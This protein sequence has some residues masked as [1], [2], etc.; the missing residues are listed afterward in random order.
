MKDTLNARFRAP[1]ADYY[2]RRIII[3]KDEAGEFADTV[4]ELQLDNARILTMRR[5][6]MFEIRKQIEVDYADENLLIYC[7]MGFE[8]MQDNWLLDVFLYSEE[9]RADYWSLVFSELN[10]QNLRPVREYAR[11]IAK[12]FAS[13]ER[14][15]QLRVL[16][17]AYANEQELQT[18]VFCVLAGIKSYGLSQVVRAVLACDPEEENPVLAAIARFCGAAAF[19]QACAD[20]YGYKGA[21]DI[22]RLACHLLATACLNASAAAALPGLPAD[23]SRALPAYG[24][25]VDWLR[26]DREGLMNLCQRVE[27][28]FD[29]VSL[30]SRLGRDALLH[31]SVFPAAD[32]LL[33]EGALTSFAEGR[34]NL[35]DTEALLRARQD[36]PWAADYAPYYAAV[37]AL[38]D[39]QRFCLAYRSGFHYTSL[40]DLWDAYCRELYRM[41]QHYRS[42]CCMYDQAL[43]LGAMALEDAL[44]AAAD[45]AERMY[46]NSYLDEINRTWT[47]LFAQQGLQELA[48]LPQQRH[49]YRDQIAKADSRVY[50]IISDGLRYETAQSLSAQLTG[51]LGGN[52]ECTGMVGTL[53]S[54][55]PVGMAALLPHRRLEM[56]DSL[57]I[58]CDGRGTEA[59]DREAV[60]RAACAEST[61][62]DYAAFRQ[63]SKAQRGELVKGRK[64]VYIYHDTIDQTGE[65]GGNVPQA[66]ET[67][68]SELTQ[69]M[70]ILVNELNAASVLITSD[71]GF[72]YTRSPLAEYDKTGKEL[73][74]GELLEYKRRYAVVRGAQAL[75]HTP[76]ITLEAL[77]RAD[78][79]A[80][81]P[82]GCLRFRLQGG[83]SS[84][85]HGGPSLQ[86]MVVPLI[87]YQNKRAG[88]KG[89]TAITK[90]EVMLLGE[91]RRISNNFFTLNF[92]QKQP[93]AGKVQPRTVLAWF[94]DAEGR[95]ISDEHQLVCDL[96][97]KEDNLRTMRITFRLLGSGYDRN[98][99]YNL[100]LR[101]KDDRAE[102]ARIPFRIDIVFENDFGF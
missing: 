63:C 32:R 42:F 55:T 101:D 82:P 67:A 74:S 5:D 76:A 78:L 72:L 58:R 36:Q 49:F 68:V 77:G 47:Q 80:A 20:A 60:L 16:K 83:G 3:W 33:L 14:R 62:L 28:R 45:M 96:T 34:L 23:A 6:A 79:Q 56:D 102:I 87:R 22:D 57:K 26:A 41:D 53:P 43:A 61:A 52:T 35:D 48:A 100:V 18:G 97:A 59:P 89:Y 24:F 12:F 75:P 73:L 39:M 2:K 64:V 99:A 51:R 98:A 1:L 13:K 8:R 15:A 88:Q 27:A 84:Y 4:A 37:R 25:F 9:F 30:L 70:R 94:E 69:L 95:P 31:M 50:V 85:V 54:V 44:K 71:H 93:C 21:E 40:R 90:A 11:T 66:C 92:Y 38:T 86:E 19:W 81:F 17:P 10:V 65:G 91:S 29:I 46:K 7:P